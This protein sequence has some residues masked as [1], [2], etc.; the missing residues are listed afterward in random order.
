MGCKAKIF[1]IK[2]KIALKTVSYPQSPQSFQHPEGK[3][4]YD[5]NLIIRI[6]SMQ[7]TTVG[8]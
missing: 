5:K 8:S 7:F 6:K 2:E 3:N 4:L 1:T